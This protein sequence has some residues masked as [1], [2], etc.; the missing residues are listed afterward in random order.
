MDDPRLVLRVE[1]NAEVVIDDMNNEA[2][3]TLYRRSVW[4]L[5]LPGNLHDLTYR[6]YDA[7][8]HGCLPV[9]M[10]VK[11]LV[12]AA[13]FAA[14]IAYERFTHFAQVEDANDVARV[15]RK[16]LASASAAG[17][18]ILAQP[19]RVVHATLINGNADLDQEACVIDLRKR[20]AA[21]RAAAPALFLEHRNCSEHEAK[22]SARLL[23]SE[24]EV[25]RGA[26]ERLQFVG[27]E[28]TL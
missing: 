14:G 21:M 26:L 17:E 7:V 24:L 27:S 11:P 22:M 18:P 4:C 9:V 23:M 1:D 16:L 8:R 12:V 2:L 25:R 5:V 20:R 3:W 15:I 10:T 28:P 6:F 19:A 13:P